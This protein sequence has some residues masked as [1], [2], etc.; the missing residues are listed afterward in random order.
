MPRIVPQA[1]DVGALPRL[2][3]ERKAA[4]MLSLGT[5]KWLEVRHLIECVQI[6]SR[7]FYSEPALA[8]FLR[9][10]TVKPVE[11]DQPRPRKRVPPRRPGRKPERER[12]TP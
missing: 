4:A 8:A 12:A 1:D 3:P 10:H 2:H 7:R 11:G 9:R 5:H 6:G